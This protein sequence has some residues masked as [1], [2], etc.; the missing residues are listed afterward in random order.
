MLRRPTLLAGLLAALFPAHAQLELPDG[1]VLASL[2]VTRAA[3]AKRDDRLDVTIES[4]GQAIRLHLEAGSVT[5]RWGERTVNAKVAGLPEPGQTG[6]L[7]LER[8]GNRV[9][10]RLGDRRLVLLPG[11]LAGP[12]ELRWEGQGVSVEPAGIQTAGDIFAA[13]DFMRDPKDAGG[14]EAV[15]GTWR[16]DQYSDPLVH[17]FGEPPQAMWYHGQAAASSGGGEGGEQPALARLGE[18]FWADYA[19]SADLELHD[20]AAGLAFNVAAANQYGLFRVS[21]GRAEVVEIT[22]AGER[23]VVAMAW[24]PE[25]DSWVR[26][27]VETSGDAFR[28]AINGRFVLA[29]RLREALS[30]PAGVWTAG[31]ADFDNL[32]VTPALLTLDTFIE[33]GLDAGRWAESTGPWKPRDGTQVAS[34]VTPDTAQPV[35]WSRADLADG[36][37]AS[38]SVALPS[39]GEAGL[40][41]AAAEARYTL[42]R[43]DDGARRGWRFGREGQPIAEGLWSEAMGLVPARLELR[44]RGPAIEAVIDGTR[45]GV[46][47]DPSPQVKVGLT[48]VGPRNG[49]LFREAAFSAQVLPP[50]TEMFRS[51]F[52]QIQVPGLYKATKHRMVGELLIPEGRGWVQPNPG[53]DDGGQVVGKVKDKPAGLWFHDIV[54]G[55]AGV[56][57]SFNA[58]DAET[59]LDLQI[60][61]EGGYRLALSATQAVLAKGAETVASMPLDSPPAEA[62]LWRDRTWVAAEVDGRWLAWQDPLPAPSGRIGLVLQAG[63]AKVGEVRVTAENGIN[64]PLGV[65]DTSWREDGVWHWNSGMSCIDWSYWITGD[66]RERHAW[67]WRRQPFGQDLN[68]EVFYGEYTDGYDDPKHQE[69][70]Q[71]FPLHDINLVIGG[72]GQDPDSGYRLWIGADGGKTTHLLRRGQIVATN[73]KFTVRMGSHCNDPRFFKVDVD[74]RGARLAIKLNDQPAFDY[75]DP[76]PFAD[77]GQV[78]LG[79]MAGRAIMTHF[80]ALAP[81][82]GDGS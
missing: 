19:L 82:L 55:D 25:P 44:R 68:L 1:P 46:W 78:S 45:Q 12:A 23:A 37:V 56:E 21:S 43:F 18:S 64:S 8:R 58:F 33:P 11:V 9:V 7:V 41:L 67:L 26:L 28:V 60:R 69:T 72:D 40:V 17:K 53:G 79:V 20:G 52:T 49:A 57:V 61:P 6:S 14:W 24:Q 10:A 63:S 30:G 74:R 80:K 16:I 48:V 75:T 47:Y 70:H 34:W 39:A 77:G 2:Q 71:H 73:P 66:A 59:R 29:G 36:G 65:V 62:R 42:T 31:Q 22:P 4:G 32:R 5:G 38:T 13:D 81:A 50:A 54:R 15:T 51:D 35:L 27:A 3:Q 76:E